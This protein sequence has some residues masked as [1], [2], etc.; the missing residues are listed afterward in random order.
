[1]RAG[2]RGMFPV[3]LM[4]PSIFS[5]DLMNEDI[6]DMSVSGVRIRCE[7]RVLSR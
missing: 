1:M 3:S 2:I 4:L 7:S 5:A 6:M